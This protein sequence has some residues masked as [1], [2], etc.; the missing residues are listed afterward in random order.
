[1]SR[2][3]FS[4]HDLLHLRV[5]REPGG[6]V[7]TKWVRRIILLS[8]QFKDGPEPIGY[9]VRIGQRIFAF[10]DV[11]YLLRGSVKVYGEFLHLAALQDVRPAGYAFPSEISDD[12]LLQLVMPTPEVFANAEERRLFYVAMT[13]ARHRVYLLGSS[14]APSAFLTEVVEEADLQRMLRFEHVNSTEQAASNKTG[15]VLSET[16]PSCGKGMLRMRSGQFGEF[17][18]CSNYPG[19]RYTRNVVAVNIRH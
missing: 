18:G 3:V 8:G 9:R 11:L 19:C 6:L 12:P 1:M 13:R 14:Y 10:H 2:G 15:A 4:C 17:L 7:G 5:R 16:C